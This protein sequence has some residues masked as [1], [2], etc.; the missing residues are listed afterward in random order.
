MDNK[1]KDIVAKLM[2]KA[3]DP[4]TSQEERDSIN[5]KVS[6]L[7]VKYGIEQAMLDAK[8]KT[9]AEIVNVT[10]NIKPPYVN[11]KKSLLYS[12]GVVFG[13]VSVRSEGKMVM[14]G[15]Q[16]DV[17]KV[18][19]LYNLLLIQL[20]NGL[21]TAEKPDY[22]HGKTFNTSWVQGFVYEVTKR[23]KEA[24][25]MAKKDVKNSAGGSGMDLVLLDRH[26][27]VAHALTARFPRLRKTSSSTSVS[28]AAG[29]NAGKSA[30]ARA[31]IGNARISGARGA[32]GR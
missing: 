27:A 24:A 6:F 2:A 32:I 12:I 21:A 5:S 26:S 11:Q 10:Y 7:M 31:D 30:G 17:E 29:Y 23:V 8:E 22:I 15:Y 4:A 18:A 9:Q 28:S 25:A 20:H 3:E 13:V 1:W 16:D 19:M 14:V